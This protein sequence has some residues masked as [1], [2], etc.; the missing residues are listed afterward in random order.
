MNEILIPRATQQQIQSASM[1]KISTL[2]NSDIFWD[3]IDTIETIEPKEDWVYDLTISEDHNFI[4]NEIF[5]HNSNVTDAIRFA[6]GETSLKSLRAKRVKDLIHTGATT[7]EVTIYFDGIKK[8]EIK[9]A[10]RNDGKILYKFNG[11]KTTRT[12]ILEEMK[13]TI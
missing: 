5:V 12:A 9:R 13:N 6:L 10:I 2:L 4:A 11:K 7:A 3:E 1:E 8:Y